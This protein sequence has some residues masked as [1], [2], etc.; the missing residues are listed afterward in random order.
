MVALSSPSAAIAAAVAAFLDAPKTCGNS[1]RFRN[2]L[3][4]Q[5]CG[6]AVLS[7]LI[8]D[9]RLPDEAFSEIHF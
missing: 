8:A 9:V 4:A 3:K 5:T 1:R 7:C 6:A 2:G